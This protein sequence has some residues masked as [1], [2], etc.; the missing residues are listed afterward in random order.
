MAKFN[1]TKPKLVLHQ[2]N[3][4]KFE[5]KSCILNQGKT[6]FYISYFIH[7]FIWAMLVTQMVKNPYVMQETQGPSLGREDLLE[8]GRLLSLAFLPGEFHGHRNLKGCSPWS[9][10]ELDT[11]EWLTHRSQVK[12]HIYLFIF[13]I[14]VICGL[15]KLNSIQQNLNP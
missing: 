3:T 5:I 11:T 13:D 2:S 1:N 10:K 9:C 7:L 15:Q 4:S 12:S 14:T 6:Y 8:K